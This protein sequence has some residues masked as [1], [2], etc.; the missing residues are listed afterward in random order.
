MAVR[1][2][3]KSGGVEPQVECGGPTFSLYI[4]S[5]QNSRASTASLESKLTLVPSGLISQLPFCRTNASNSQSFQPPEMVTPHCLTSLPSRTV[6]FLAVSLNSAQ[7]W[8]GR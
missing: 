3:T 5:T 2:A 6:S 8:G 4:R 1:C 7:V